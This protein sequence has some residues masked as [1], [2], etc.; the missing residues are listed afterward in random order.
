MKR[1]VLAFL[2]IA[3]AG[4]ESLVGFVKDEPLVI[5]I[6]HDQTYYENLI[7]KHEGFSQTAYKDRVGIA[8]GYGRNLTTNGVTREEALYLL[9]NDI[10]KL[11]DQLAKQIPA[12]QRLNDVRYAVVLSMAYTLGVNG[13][14]KFDRM[15]S[16]I[17][18]RQFVMAANQMI[19]SDWCRQVN[20]RCLELA[21]MMETGNPATRWN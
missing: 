14:S 7:I 20:N 19:L 11:N 9:R 15:W 8:V 2:L 12:S 13:L 3:V 10:E 16:A 4:C 17:E 21:E 5:D 1:L 18:Q 6:T